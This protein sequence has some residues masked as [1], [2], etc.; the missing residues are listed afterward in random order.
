MAH[1]SHFLKVMAEQDGEKI[2]LQKSHI[3]RI[4]SKL[5]VVLRLL[6]HIPYFAGYV[7]SPPGIY[8]FIHLIIGPFTTYRDIPLVL[9]RDF[10]K[11][12]RTGCG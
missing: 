12:F 8:L 4:V 3:F 6:G 10:G 9:A 5:F 7:A 1:K 2:H 11:S